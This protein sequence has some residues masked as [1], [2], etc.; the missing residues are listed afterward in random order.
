MARVDRRTRNLARA[1]AAGRDRRH[2]P[3]RHRP[4][5][6]RGAGRG[7]GGRR[8]QRC[9]VHLRSLP[10]PRAAVPGR[11]R[12]CCCSTTS[13]R[14]SCTPSTTAAG[15]AS[16]AARLRRRR[17]R[18]HRRRAGRRR[19]VAA[20][21]E[22]AEGRASRASSRR[23]ARTRSST[24][25]GSATCC[26]TATGFPSW[27]T[28]IEGRHVLVVV[29]AFDYRRDL[30]SLQGLHPRATP[31]LI[32]VDGGRRRAA[33][34]RAP[35]RRHHRATATA[36][37]TRRCAAAPRWSSRPAT[38]AG[39]ATASASSGSA[40]ATRPSRP[41]AD[42]R[43]R[44]AAR[45]RQRGLA[46]RHRRHAR[47]PRGVPRHAVR[48]E[49]G[50]L[51]P[52]PAPRSARASRTRRPSPSSTA[53]G[54]AA[55]WCSCCCS[56]RWSRSARRSPPRR[57][58]RTGGTS[59][60]AGWSTATTGS[61]AGLM[62]ALRRYVFAFVA[63]CA[64]VR[65]R[66]SRSATAAPG[67]LRRSSDERRRWPKRNA[68][69]P[70][71]QRACAQTR[72]SAEAVGRGRRPG[73]VAGS[74]RTPRSACSCCRAS[75]RPTVAGVTEAV[76]GAGGEACRRATLS[77]HA[78][79]PRQEDVRRQRRPTSC[80]TGFKDLRVRGD[81]PTY[82]RIGALLAGAYTGTVTRSPSTTRPTGSTRSSQGAELRHRSASLCSVAPAPWSCSA[83]GD[84]GDADPV[85]ARP[86]D[87]AAAR[88]RAGHAGRR[89]AAGGPAR[90]ASR[91]PGRPGQRRARPR[92]TPSRR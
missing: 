92:R 48:S 42:G 88:R 44:A 66:R 39:S 24:C 3:R 81:L 11:R 83:P 54:S 17:G 28:P 80:C 5:R 20:A 59:C 70:T 35:A 53:A 75:R 74:L 76:T 78:G 51:V 25:A 6:R 26:S 46:D 31:V 29:Q 90:P 52:R 67:R 82:E 10:Q 15:S 32:G 1:A 60:A 41:A 87:R 79:R 43:R 63:V 9:T 13:A 68:S 22:D 47:A 58:A 77:R 34:G 49:H 61:G 8:R 21:M 55:G 40:C 91:R 4:S 19:S 7:R 38:T 84:H 73:L 69:S 27:R 23:S 14:R 89:A 56:S 12:A 33:R 37:P 62:I 64:G 72:R 71:S 30:A 57:S 45:A 86:P 36:S 18:R 65:G 2:R 16:T 85:Y 50:Q